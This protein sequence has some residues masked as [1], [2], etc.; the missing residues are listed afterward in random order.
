MY[1]RVER[2]NGISVIIKGGILENPKNNHNWTITYQ[3]KTFY[4]NSIFDIIK[5]ECYAFKV[6]GEL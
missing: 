4:L 3:Q 6:E 2:S 1:F 5:I